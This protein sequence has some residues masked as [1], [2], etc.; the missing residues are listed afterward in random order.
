MQIF[1]ETIV[2]EEPLPPDC[3]TGLGEAPAPAEHRGELI[4]LRPLKVLVLSSDRNFRIVV[5]LLLARRGCEVGSARVFEA[6]GQEP[7]LPVP[8]DVVLIDAGDSGSSAT[9]AV[10]Y[11][12]ALQASVGVV[13]VAGSECL[14]MQRAPFLGRWGPFPELYAA[15]QR[16]DGRRRAGLG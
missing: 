3:S 5:R 16:A 13:L 2:D 9:R 8:A 1:R 7:T 4:R 12:Q 14:D 10:E 11:A 15:I 6:L